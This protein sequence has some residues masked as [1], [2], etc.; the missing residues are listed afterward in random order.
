LAADQPGSFGGGPDAASAVILFALTRCHLVSAFPDAHHYDDQT[1][2]SVLRALSK[3]F[4]EMREEGY[5]HKD[6]I[7]LTRSPILGAGWE[8]PQ[9]RRYAETR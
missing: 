9:A 2:P 4:R 5:D 8:R 6:I 3:F 7:V 1:A